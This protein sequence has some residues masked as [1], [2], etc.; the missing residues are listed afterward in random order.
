VS[1]G[2]VRFD[3]YGRFQIEVL[4]TSSGW[5]AYRSSNGLRTPYE[6]LVFPQELRES[7]LERFLDDHFHEYALPGQVIRRVPQAGGSDDVLFVK[8]SA[9]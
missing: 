3:I 6:E 2:A 1:T 5:V 9:S 7:E 8:R 4:M